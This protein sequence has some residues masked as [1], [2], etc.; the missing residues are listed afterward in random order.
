M[1]G[2]A[3]YTAKVCLYGQAAKGMIYTFALRFNVMTY[4]SKQ[5][6]HEKKK[7]TF[8]TFAC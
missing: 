4:V 5:Y 8:Y 6:N 1:S 3:D 2:T 7:Y